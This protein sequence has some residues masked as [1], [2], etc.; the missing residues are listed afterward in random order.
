DELRRFLDAWP[1]SVQLA[2]EVRHPDWF[3]MSNHEALNDM[4]SGYGMARVVIDTRP[5]RNLHGE[6]ILAG[7]VY[8]RLLEARLRKPDVPVLPESTTP[9]VFLRY[10][11]HPQMEVNQ[12]YIKEWGDYLA[13]RLKMA[14]DA[15]VFCHCP[16][17]RLDPWLCRAFYQELSGKMRLPPLPWEQADAGTARQGRLF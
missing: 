14:A 2:V 10:I 12:P 17:E 3:E 11:G 1:R 9:F 15:Y 8:K 5:I 6:R 4:L 13:G 16:D 7:S